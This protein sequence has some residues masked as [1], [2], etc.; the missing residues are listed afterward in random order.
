MKKMLI[1]MMVAAIAAVTGCKTTPTV[2]AME[3]S[4]NSIGI[5]AGLVAN[6]LKI[7]DKDRNVVV[8]IIGE[9]SS[10]VPTNGQSFASAWTPKAKEITDKLVEEGKIDAGSQVLI[11]KAFDL[12]CTGL[13]YI[14]DVRYPTAREYADLI[15]AAVR[16]FTSGFLTVFKPADA[17]DTKILQSPAIE[18][19]EEA[20]KYFRAMAVS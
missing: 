19:D 8:D 10:C 18:P 14:F 1:A 9:V 4:A 15:S 11:V 12:V 2:E 17:A 13:D 7:E 3:K 5:A 20:L 16:G 6:Q